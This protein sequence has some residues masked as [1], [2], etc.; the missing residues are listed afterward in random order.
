M[1]LPIMYHH[2]G[3]DN[4]SNRPD[5]FR[6]HLLYIQQHFHVVLPGEPLA[7][8]KPNI[9][10]TFDD[11]GYSFYHYVFPLLKEF[12]LRALLGVPVRFILEDSTNV[13]AETRLDIST[14]QMMRGELYK[15]IVPFCTWKELRAMSECGLVR[16][17]SH[18]LSHVN[19]LQ[20]KWYAEELTDSQAVL[21]EKLGHAVDAFVFP[22]GEFNREI[23]SA[24]RDRYRYLFAV[25]AGD[26]R[27]WDG[28]GGVLFRLYGDELPDATSIFSKNK[29]LRYML[30]YHKLRIKKWLKDRQP[31][32][33]RDSEIQYPPRNDENSPRS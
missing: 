10:L 16:C 20:S 28:I 2:I 27:T 3:A 24:A 7:T 18:S 4:F 8:D 12:N 22:Y 5:V 32:A 25:G 14:F 1:L 30:S 6:D 15:Q 21:Q 31:L 17:A 11:A 19:L 29:M 33:P 26:N 23:L 13:D 9:V